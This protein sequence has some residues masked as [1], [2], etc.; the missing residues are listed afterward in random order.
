MLRPQELIDRR[1]RCELI[2]AFARL[3]QEFRGHESIRDA[4]YKSRSAKFWG[5]R[6]TLPE[7]ETGLAPTGA[8]IEAPAA[9]LRGMAE[10]TRRVVALA[11]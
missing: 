6:D 5:T 9:M 7:D 2:A 4:I 3:G 10:L 11:L 8:A 1:D